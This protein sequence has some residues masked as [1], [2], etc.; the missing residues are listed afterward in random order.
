MNCLLVTVLYS[1]AAVGLCFSS[2]LYFFIKEVGTERC[3]TPEQKE[4]DIA[5]CLGKKKDCL[6]AEVERCSEN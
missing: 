4:S 3:S 5:L 2:E 1:F 6:K